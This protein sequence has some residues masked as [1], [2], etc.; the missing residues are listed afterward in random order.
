MAERPVL[1]RADAGV[2]IGTGH[3]TRD[4]VLAQA[5]ARE[6]VSAVWLCRP[7]PESVEALLRDAGFR[8][9]PMDAVPGAREADAVVAAAEG[10][11]ARAVV[12]DHYGIDRTTEARVRAAGFPLLAVDDMY[13]PHDCDLLL[14]QNLYASR[15][16]YRGLVPED[17]RILCGW[18]HALLRDEFALLPRR[19]RVPPPPDGARILVTLGG[20]DHPNVSLRVLGALER[21]QGLRSVRVDIVIGGSNVHRDAVAVA[22]AASPLDVTLLTDVRD[23]ARRMDRADLAVTAGGTTHLELVAT[24]LPAL[25]VT[26]ADNQERV[27]E[28]MGRHGLALDLGRHEDL[29]EERITDAA[30]QLL[31]DPERYLEMHRRLA[32]HGPAGGADR[33]ARALLGLDLRSF[34]LAPMEPGDLMDAFR[35]TNDPSVRARSFGTAPIPLDEHRRWFSGR[36]AA[37]GSPFYAVRVPGR[38]F[39][40]QIR[41]DPDASE[42]GRWTVSLALDPA[43]QGHGLGRLVI[44]A[45][46]RKALRGGGPHRVDAWVVRGNPAS[47]RSFLGAGFQEAGEETIRGKR[48]RRFVFKGE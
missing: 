18:R 13:V 16:A 19:N 47:E 4:L 6:G 44:R 22:A 27:T 33:V 2:E 23:M 17:C 34:V 8:G 20:A 43:A 14:N 32:E 37:A 45:A 15:D 7:L 24:A 1:I 9:L 29:D 31:R 10:I 25:M 39:I 5:L 46:L 12:V 48:A 26:I 36:I 42:A 40:G 41:L 30:E 35:L 28:H 38:G 3:V 21:V 11:N